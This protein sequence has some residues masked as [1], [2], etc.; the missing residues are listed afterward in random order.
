MTKTAIVYARF[1]TA[2]QRHGFSLERQTTLGLE[3]AAQHGWT[4]EKTIS[5]EGKSAFH[6][7]NRVE[8]SELHTF[9]LEARN[10]LH[11]GK[12]LVVE[13]IDR[14]SRQG[15]KIAAELIWG[16][17]RH[18]VDV[19]TYHDNTT[20][21]AA[22]G[23]DMMELFGLI[24]K[25]QLAYEESVKRSD[26]TKATWDNRY[27]GISSG[28]RKTM[29]GR[30]PSWVK[31]VENGYVL[32]EH[33]ANVLNE[34]FDLYIDGMG[35]HLI[36]NKL[37]ERGEPSWAVNKKRVTRGGWYVAYIYRLLQKRA[38]LGE[39]ETLKGE[40][41]ATDFFPQAITAEKFNQAQAVLA[42]K[43]S[44]AK[45]DRNKV[46]SILTKLVHC[47]Y[48][49]GGSAFEDKGTGGVTTYKTKSGEVRSYPHKHYQRLRCDRNRR[50][51][52]CDNSTILEYQIVERT[53]L[54]GMLPNLINRKEPTQT[55]HLRNQIAEL[56]RQ[57]DVNSRR[58]GNLLDILADSPSRATSE[59]MKALEAETEALELQI[60][61]LQRQL[62][63]ELAK[64]SSMDDA[65]LIEALKA[66]LT[67]SDP[68]IRH[69]ARQK[70]NI[71]LRRLIRRIDIETQTFRIWLNDKEWYWFDAEGTML[72]SQQVWDTAA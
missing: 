58:V 28:S 36:A 64:P 11:S 3:Y 40:T 10:G 49:G 12:T 16:L 33:R 62:D 20:Y 26:R 15:A 50:K 56:A 66:E 38:V 35:I 55:S 39:Y 70:A 23:G 25:A 30:A 14:L 8:G 19:A 41:L 60:S 68:E 21:T 27:A 71:A 63:I 2:D 4:V 53:V 29:A 67:H 5:D 37:N 72:E 1:S 44:N 34:I 32:D 13:N 61:A 7:A 18:G 42:M 31:R 69:P 65:K 22:N 48:C 52:Q 45:R 43:K 17:N 24:I 54:E 57:K 47:A 9:E 51:H 59:R 46:T 6:G